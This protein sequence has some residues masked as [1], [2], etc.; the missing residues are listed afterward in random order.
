MS[1]VLSRQK[2]ELDKG[3]FEKG[4]FVSNADNIKRYDHENNPIAKTIDFTHFL[5]DP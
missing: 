3:L 4:Y 2:D 5:I 1:I